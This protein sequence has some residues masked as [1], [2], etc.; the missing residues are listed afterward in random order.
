M[1]LVREHA[2]AEFLAE[3]AGLEADRKKDERAITIQQ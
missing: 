2:D 3:E 1:D